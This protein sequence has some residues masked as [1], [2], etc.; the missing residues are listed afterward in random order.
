VP[1]GNPDPE[2]ERIRKREVRRRRITADHAARQARR[3]AAIAGRPE[4]SAELLA[5][6]A[7]MF[8]GEGTVSIT[9]SGP[10]YTVCVVTLCNTDR[11][12]IDVFNEHWPSRKIVVREPHGN[13]R[14]QWTWTLHGDRIVGFLQDLRPYLRTDAEKAKF[15]IVEEAQ[16]LRRRGYRTQPHLDRLTELHQQIRVLNK[17][18]V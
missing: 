15:D 6:A 13:A 17:R 14:R 2:K 9:K 5:W 12:I 1:Y 18:G 10:K 7:G 3:L 4:H 8:E 11:Q 16:L